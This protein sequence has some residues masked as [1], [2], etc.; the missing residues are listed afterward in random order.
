[1]G[2]NN[3]RV[4]PP[5][6]VAAQEQGLCVCVGLCVFV[7][8]CVC[9]CVGGCVCGWVCVCVHVC[10]CACVGVYSIAKT[11]AGMWMY[12]WICGTLIMSFCNQTDRP[13]PHHNMCKGTYLCVCAMHGCYK[14]MH[15]D[16][17]VAENVY[18][19]ECTPPITQI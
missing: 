8:V 17:V 10:V 7:C 3:T 6:F 9:V 13:L 19:C 14:F 4:C 18:L 11:C 12:A 5:F 15:W 16:I 2:A 1:M